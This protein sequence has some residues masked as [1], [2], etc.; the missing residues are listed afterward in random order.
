MDLIRVL[1][2]RPPASRRCVVAIG[3]FDGVHLGHQALV[4]RAQTLA[5]ELGALAAVLTFEPMPLEVLRPAAAPARLMRLRDKVL[6]LEELGLDRLYVARFDARLQAMTPADFEALVARDL[7]AVHVVVGANFRYAHGRSGSIETLRAAGAGVGFGVDV[8]EPVACPNGERVSSTRV[9]EAL[10]RDELD[11]A[12]EL[13]GRPY[14]ISGRVVHGEHLGRTLGYP[15]ANLKL[16]RGRPPLAGIY[17]VR[18][19]LAGVSYPAVASLGTRP[20]VGGVE[21]LLETHLFDFEGDLYGRCLGVEFVEKLRSEERFASLD[22][23]VVQ[24]N[25]DAAR[26]RAVLARNS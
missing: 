16:G 20:T 21:P 4:R 8:I 14:R 10:A 13:I 7:G 2:A 6:A 24:M 23:L 12:R 17:A 26:A 25:E 3:N 5:A 22:A 15:T 1:P 19:H 11:H 18:A 9:R